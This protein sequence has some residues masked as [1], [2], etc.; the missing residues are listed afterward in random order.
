MVRQTPLAKIWR[1]AFFFLGPSVPRPLLLRLEATLSAAHSV[2]RTIPI[3]WEVDYFSDYFSTGSP[4]D[5]LAADLDS[6]FLNGW[7]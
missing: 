2:K 1:I 3:A 5:G 4:S 7:L 6:I